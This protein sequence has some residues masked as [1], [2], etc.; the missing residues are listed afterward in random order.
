MAIAAMIRII[1]TTISNSIS[2]KPFC[3]RISRCPLLH[4]QNLVLS[5][6]SVWS[7]IRILATTTGGNQRA[8]P[9]FLA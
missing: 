5:R 9:H 1:A 3:L 8:W 2:E 4:D 6:P 7:H